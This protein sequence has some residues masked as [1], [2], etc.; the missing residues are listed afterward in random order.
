VQKR[1]FGVTVP[2]LGR[3]KAKTGHKLVCHT[4][5]ILGAM[6]SPDEN[7]RASIVMMQEKAQQW[8]NAVHNGHLHRR[9][10]WFFLKAQLWPR[11]GYGF[12][13]STATFEEL[14]KALH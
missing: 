9:N 12:C 5:K 14:S 1:E 7:S 11:M 6:T 3:G 13:S 4:K 2:L 10:V 8:V